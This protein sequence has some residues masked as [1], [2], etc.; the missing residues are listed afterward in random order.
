[1]T[2]P[3]DKPSSSGTV[4]KV[5]TGKLYI[6]T[7]RSVSVLKAWPKPMAWKKDFRN[8]IWFHYR[9]MISI[10]NRN[11]DKYIEQLETPTDEYGQYLFP[12]CL[13]PGKASVLRKMRMW[14]QWYDTIPKEIRD[15][16]S[17]FPSRQWHLLSFFFMGFPSASSKTA[18]SISTN[19]A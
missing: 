4:F 15:Y 16:V 9:P 7:A 13:P 3:E 1:M 19:F 2:K 5:E 10:P 8:Q 6:F 17:C 18:L 14:T 11:L 12:F